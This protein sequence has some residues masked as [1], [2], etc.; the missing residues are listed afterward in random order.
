MKPAI[1]VSLLLFAVAPLSYSQDDAGLKTD[2]AQQAGFQHVF[3]SVIHP[4]R[5][6]AA[7]QVSVRLIIHSG[8]LL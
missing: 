2:R 6:R 8:P 5:R 1:A 4:G 7:A 3:Q